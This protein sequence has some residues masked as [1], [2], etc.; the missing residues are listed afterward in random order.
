M[1]ATPSTRRRDQQS[2]HTTF[3]PHGDD[4]DVDL[5]GRPARLHA[6]QG[7]LRALVLALKVAEIQQ[8]IDGEFSTNVG[9]YGSIRIMHRS[10]PNLATFSSIAQAALQAM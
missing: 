5:D 1:S 3:G 8:L 7:Q 9:R 10:E 6:S 2:G 4:L